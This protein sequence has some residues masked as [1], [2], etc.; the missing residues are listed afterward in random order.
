MAT[1]S[2]DALPITVA[3]VTKTYGKVH[4][5]DDVSL[6]VKSGEFL[7]LLGPSGSGKSTLLMVLAGF[8]RPDHGSLKFGDTEVIRTAPHLREVGMTFQNYALFPHMTVAGNVGYPLRLRKRPKAEIAERVEK[9]LETVQL[10]GFGNRRIDQLS[11]GQRQRVAVARAIVFE[12]RILLMDEPLSALDKKL[13]DQM[14]IELR[15]LHEKLG[16][17]TVYVTHDQRE[18]LTMSDRIAVVNHGRI[19]QLATPHDLYERPANRF[20]ADF[21]GDSTFLK[22]TRQG[23]RIT[24][25]DM[26]LAHGAPAPDTAELAMMLRPERIALSDSGPV[27]G[28]NNFAATAENV[29]YQGDSYLVQARLSDGAEIILRRAMSGATATT[30]PAP[31]DAITPT[32]APED[33][34]LID[35]REV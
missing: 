19:M 28:A 16:M 18:A 9:A 4:A 31:G 26:A 25:G 24:W 35:G 1:A 33:T 27:E 11:G 14:Q 32:V 20:V 30:M 3:N 7:T 34:V 2:K 6:E 13:R 29:V 5:L 15:R 10:G 8:T 21:I 23:D 17:T 12:P 22:V